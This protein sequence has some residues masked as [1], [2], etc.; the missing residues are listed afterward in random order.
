MNWA[1]T[2]LAHLLV[3]FL[4]GFDPARSLLL[5]FHILDSQPP[6]QHANWR[7]RFY[8]QLMLRQW[9]TLI[10][11]VLIFFGQGWSLH[12]LGLQLPAITLPALCLVVV[13]LVVFLD[14][15]LLFRSWISPRERRSSER[16]ASLRQSLTLMVP[17]TPTERLFFVLLSLTAGICEEV[18][19]RGFLPA[20]LTSIFPHISFVFALL[21]AAFFF[22]L[23][24]APQKAVIIGNSITGVI[25]GFLYLFTGSLFFSV[26]LHAVQDLRILLVDVANV[27]DLPE[28]SVEQSTSSPS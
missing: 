15:P 19:F 16:L 27:T 22:G 8:A 13:F 5:H 6:A 2:L 10:P 21:L 12:T 23:A 26:L 1:S 14:F 4:I 24:H 18:L 17:H 7:A 20:Y 25:Y 11:L 3:L 9:L 28:R